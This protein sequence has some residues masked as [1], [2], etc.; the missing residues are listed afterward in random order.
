MCTGAM[1]GG[2]ASIIRP[3]DAK[4]SG[5]GHNAPLVITVFM[6]PHAEAL[7]TMC[8]AIAWCHHTAPHNSGGFVLQRSSHI[9]PIVLRHVPPSL[10]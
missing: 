8:G 10:N 7:P 2:L 3:F 1:T 6:R 4:M 5:T 9:H